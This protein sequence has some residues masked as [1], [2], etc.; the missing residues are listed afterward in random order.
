M[1]SSNKRDTH[2]T[3]ENDRKEGAYHDIFLRAYIVSANQ[4]KISKPKRDF[5][6][7]WPNHALV[8]DTETRI[9]VD[10]SL[11]FGVYRCCERVYGIYKVTEE[12]I[13]YADNLPAKER[14]ILQA[15]VR[16]A[17]SDV[18]S[19]PPRFPLYSRSEFMK[20]VF[21]PTIKHK[22]TLVCGFNL[23]FDL[24]RLALK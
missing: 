16:T 9:T 17:V 3:F 7:K 15:H 22:A 2:S 5:R 18:A 24:A 8:F 14:K 23:P 1:K 6:A 21:W 12:G 11:T 4:K 20:R 19:F 13:F 10:Q